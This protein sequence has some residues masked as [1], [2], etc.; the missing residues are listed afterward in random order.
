MQQKFKF[1]FLT[2]TLFSIVGAYLKLNTVAGAN[3]VLAIAILATIAYIVVGIYEVQTSPK[4]QNA[5]KIVWTIGFL[6]FPF[7]VGLLY[8]ASGRKRVV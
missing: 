3:F 2:S 4:I 5:K 6:T 1:S 7:L 8:L